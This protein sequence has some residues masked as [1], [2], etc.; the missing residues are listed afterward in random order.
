MGGGV[1]A[2]E[3]RLYDA[4]GSSLQRC[5]IFFLIPG[6]LGEQIASPRVDTIIYIHS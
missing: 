1:Q 3:D 4:S 2:M 6:A 5:G